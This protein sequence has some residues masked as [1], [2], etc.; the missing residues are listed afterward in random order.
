MNL[1]RIINPTQ[2]CELVRLGED[3]VYKKDGVLVEVDSNMPIHNFGL[4]DFYWRS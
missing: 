2:V 3:I 4:Y 1:A